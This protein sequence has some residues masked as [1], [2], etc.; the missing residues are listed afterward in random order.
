MN[1]N[2]QGRIMMLKVE[3]TRHANGVDKNTK[4]QQRKGDVEMS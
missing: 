1:Q 4:G 3:N 2:Q